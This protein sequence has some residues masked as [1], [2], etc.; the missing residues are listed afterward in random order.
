MT[1][2]DVI[3]QGESAKMENNSKKSEQNIDNDGGGGSNKKMKELKL[4]GSVEKQ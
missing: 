3:T 1:V 2:L 4:N